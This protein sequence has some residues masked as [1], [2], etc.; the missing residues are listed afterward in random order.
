MFELN[1][2]KNKNVELFQSF[3]NSDLGNFKN[4]Q[5]YIPIY[6]KYFNCNKTNW[7]NINLNQANYIKSIQ[8]KEGEHIFNIT[9]HNDVSTK[10]FIKYS[11]LID[12]IKYLAGKYKKY[13]DDYLF[14]MPTYEENTKTF[15]KVNDANNVSYVDGFFSYLTSQLLHTQNF[16]HGLDFY[17][18]FIGVKHNFKIDIADDFDFLQNYDYFM[19]QNNKLFTIEVDDEEICANDTRNF[20]KRLCFTEKSIANL[21][22][23]SFCDSDFDEIFQSSEVNNTAID[24]CD[25]NVSSNMVYEQNQTSLK[26]C[27]NTKY[28]NSSSSSCSSRSSNTSCSSIDSDMRDDMNDD[29]NSEM[30]SG[31]N[32]S[33]S[34]NQSIVNELMLVDDTTLEKLIQES[35]CEDISNSQNLNNSNGSN[36]SNNPSNNNSITSYSSTLSSETTSSSSSTSSEESIIVSINEFPV[37][38]ISLEKLNATLDRYMCSNKISV[39]EWK[40]ILFQIIVSLYVYQKLFDFTHNDLHTNNIMYYETEETHIAYKIEGIIYKVPTFGKIYKIIDFGRSIYRFKNNLHCSDSFKKNEDAATQYNFPPFYNDSKPL[41]KPNYSFDLCRLGCSLFDNFFD[42]V[43]D[44]EEETNP[45]AL[46]VAEWCTDDKG[47]SVLYKKNNK[48]RYPGFKLYKM[49]ARTVHKHTPSQQFKDNFFSCFVN[50]ERNINVK[51]M[52]NIDNYTVCYSK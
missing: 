15:S 17:G 1:Y 7:N 35:M 52:M 5:N 45:I 14:A 6:S 50:E 10:T 36:N 19:K 42:S 2:N 8:N 34:S 22:V 44:I 37:Q 39:E 30:N 38:I 48:E 4:I 31:S 12:P 11:P 29:I 16:I 25:V 49:I 47:R 3:R 27:N 32:C 51:N 26:S 13:T 46:K 21:S 43:D 18:S 33:T 23:A 20:K 41:I 24:M 40:S 9:L 28:S